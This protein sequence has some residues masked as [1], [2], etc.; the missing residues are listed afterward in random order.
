MATLRLIQGDEAWTECAIESPSMF[1]GRS[2]KECA[3]VL[4]DETVSRKHAEI[5]RDRGEYYL[6]DLRSRAGTLLNGQRL[7]K[8]IGYRLKQ[9]DEIKI[10]NYVLQ[11]LDDES[12]GSSVRIT[13]RE[14]AT[15]SQIV[16]DGS[17][18]SWKNRVRVKWR[19][20]QARRPGSSIPRRAVPGR[21]S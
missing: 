12:S 20:T 3:I 4:S 14:T 16:L 17:S 1:I 5:T 10:C 18:G 19:A 13:E 8:N 7:V 21:V 2:K 15:F 9:N 6:I 11:F